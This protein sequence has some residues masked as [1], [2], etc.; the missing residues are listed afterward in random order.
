MA[1]LD[2]FSKVR[3]SDPN[4]KGF[5][6]GLLPE[7][8]AVFSSLFGMSSSMLSASSWVSDSLSILDMVTP[9]E[10]DEVLLKKRMV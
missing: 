4:D 9:E 1:L 5:R 8:R 10:D 7:L 2:N 6:R 3:S